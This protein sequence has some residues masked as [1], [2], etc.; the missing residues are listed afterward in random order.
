MIHAADIVGAGISDGG[1]RPIFLE[2]ESIH[3]SLY[4]SVRNV[5]LKIVT[6]LLTHLSKD[7]Y[8][9]DYYLLESNGNEQKTVSLSNLGEFGK[10]IDGGREKFH[11]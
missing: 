11:L 3:L 7:I 1:N 2:I 6:Y 10:L 8:A 4:V 5:Y 9:L